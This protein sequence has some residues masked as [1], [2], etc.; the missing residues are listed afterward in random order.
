MR[1]IPHTQADRQAMLDEIGV[2]SVERL[3]DDIPA[4]VTDRFRPLELAPKSEM[5]VARALEGLASLNAAPR[6]PVSFLGGGIYDHYVPSVVAHLTSRSE[7]YTAY[8]PYQ[9]EISQGTLTAMF[10]F[11]TLVCELTGMEVAN[12]SL[13]DGATALAEAALMAVR[14]VGRPRIAVARSLFGHFR[15]VVDT[16]AWA[17]GIEVVEVPYTSAGCLDRSAIPE[18]V[19]GLLVQSPN[20]FGVIEDLGGLKEALGEGLLVVAVHPLSLGVLTPPG[21]RGADVVV[22]EGQPLG[23][24]ASFGGPLL[25]LFACRER[26]LRQMP[27]RIAGRTVDVDGT[28]GYTMAVATREQHI[29][30]ERATSNICT[31][32]ALCALTATVYLATLGAEGLRELALLNLNKAHYLAEKAAALPGHSLVFDAP[33]FNEFVLRLPSEPRRIRSRL[34][35]E[36]FLVEDPEPLARL[37]LPGALR[38]AVTEKR[39]KEEL[40]RFVRVLGGIR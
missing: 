14:V 29:R 4:R 21:E 13:Y 20:A 1:Y 32:S 17:A 7:F 15:R 33:F 30:R 16:Y 27:G 11:Q 24:P 19:A 39:T 10:E 12:A 18:G 8:T 37:G 28:V 31:N 2:S 26:Y 40:D 35:E 25:G 5:E 38:L 6:E 36:G 22:G 3:F 9:P 34:A 23:L